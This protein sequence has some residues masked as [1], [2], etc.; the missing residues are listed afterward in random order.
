MGYLLGSLPFGVIAGWAFKRIDIR[1]YGSGSTGMTNVTRAVGVPA[2]IAVMVLDMGKAALAVILAKVFSD[3]HGVAAAAALAALV[4]H[5]W[6]VFIGFQG[7]KGV[8]SGY[9]ALFVLSPIA[10]LASTVAG[11]PLVAITRYMSV[12][13]LAGAAAGV[14][15]LAVLS[16][17]SY[18]EPEYIWFALIAGALVLAKHKEN[19]RKLL[20]GEERKLGQAAGPAPGRS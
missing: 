4:G 11:A 8:A 1:D 19:I 3:S 5:I 9:A 17:T 20:K 12:G 7:G 18:G 10:A 16:F 13:S 14:V 6:P 15:T 2:G